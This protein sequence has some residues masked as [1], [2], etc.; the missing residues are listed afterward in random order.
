[1]FFMSKTAGQLVRETLAEFPSRQL[2]GLFLSPFGNVAVMEGERGKLLFWA[3]G[4]N[5]CHIDEKPPYRLSDFFNLPKVRWVLES[6]FVQH[7]C[8]DI[9]PTV[10]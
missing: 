6:D 3:P 5:R 1:M 9:A 8:E 10:H 2:C 7:C 4:A